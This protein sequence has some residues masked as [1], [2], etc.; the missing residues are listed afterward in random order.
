MG[1]KSTVGELL[2]SLYFKI[3]GSA[4]RLSSTSRRGEIVVSFNPDATSVTCLLTIE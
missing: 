1:A 4:V 2:K 3:N